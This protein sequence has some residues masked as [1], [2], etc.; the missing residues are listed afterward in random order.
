[1]TTSSPRPSSVRLRLAN[2]SD[3]RPIWE[4]YVEAVLARQRQEEAPSRAVI[5]SERKTGAQPVARTS[6]RLRVRDGGLDM[7]GRAS[8]S[9]Q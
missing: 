4:P 5:T 3:P 2:R 9:N 1:M 7:V 6:S 8:A